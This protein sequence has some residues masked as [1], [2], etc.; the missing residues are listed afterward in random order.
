MFELH[1]IIIKKPMQSNSNTKPGSTLLR[2]FF[3]LVGIIAT[4]AYRITPFLD[5]LA[6]KIAWYTG[7][8]G[9]ILYFWHRFHIENK[10]AQMVKDFDLIK[11]V[12]QSDIHGSQ[13]SAVAYLVKTSLT[14]KARFN[15]LFILIAS[16]LALITSI[17]IDVL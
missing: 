12:S 17:A 11:A 13:K 1:D 7:T 8:V 9:F 10:R 14:S 15:S 2:I 16:A 3:F 5:P 6:V 4:I